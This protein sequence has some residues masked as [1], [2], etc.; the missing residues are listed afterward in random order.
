[1]KLPGPVPSLLALLFAA[2]ACAAEYSVPSS[3]SQGHAFPASVSDSS[4][5]TA[6]FGW[7]GEV[8][9]VPARQSGN[10]WKSEILLA[11][12]IDAAEKGM[13]TIRHGETSKKF[14]VAPASV[15]WPRSIL[16]VEPRY[17]VPPR[18]TQERIAREAEESR[19]AYALRTPREWSL[20]LARPVPGGITSPFGGRRV[21]NGKPRAP[22]K[23]TDMRSPEGAP[24]M[25]AADGTVALAGHQYFGGRSVFVD[26]GQGVV[27]TYCHLSSIGVKPGQKVK[28][29]SEIGRSGSTGRVTGP[30]LHF[31]MFVQGVAVDA[32]PLLSFPP[33]VVGGPSKP[34]SSGR[35]SKAA[36]RK[37]Q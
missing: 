36:A 16:K 5:F 2:Q 23:G 31:G 15:P 4:P 22:H 37:K 19:R 14:T 34:L 13:L 32:M 10:A 28:K 25:A 18:E 20:P 9:D 21:F 7:R 6:S 27:T 1:M 8:I 3:V 12:P 26:H 17:V 11:F 33:A 24:V 35:Q 30:H 29:G